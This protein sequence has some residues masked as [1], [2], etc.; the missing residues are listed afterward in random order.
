V[1]IIQ[2]LRAAV[3]AEAY[4]QIAAMV[5]YRLEEIERESARVQIEIIAASEL[6][7]TARAFLE[8]LPKVDELI[9][10]LTAPEIF[11]FME[12]S[13]FKCRDPLPSYYRRKDFPEYQP[14]LGIEEE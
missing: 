7:E 5:K 8:S 1:L 9:R 10:P 2:D 12:G 4:Q 14:D 11:A 6:T 13:E 3:R